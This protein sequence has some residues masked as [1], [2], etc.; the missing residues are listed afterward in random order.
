M[1]TYDPTS[2]GTDTRIRSNQSND[3]T[4]TDDL[5]NGGDHGYSANV[6]NDGDVDQDVS[7]N[8]D[9]SVDAI[10]QAGDGID[11]IND[12]INVG[13]DLTIDASSAASA[14]G[15]GVALAFDQGIAMGANIQSNEVTGSVTGGNSDIA[16]VGGDGAGL[17]SN[18][19]GSS[20]GLNDTDTLIRA[21]QSNTADD[22][23]TLVD[24]TVVNGYGNHLDQT[25]EV[26]GGDA[27]SGNGIISNNGQGAGAN[28]QVGDDESISGSTAAQA[29]ASGLARSFNQNLQTGSNQQGNNVD[30]AIT[31][32]DVDVASAG[33]SGA[34]TTPSATTSGNSDTNT[35]GRVNQSN[36]L[37]DGV[38]DDYN[39]SSNFDGAIVDPL[40]QNR[41]DVSQSI[42]AEGGEATTED[43]INIS[44]GF[45][46]SDAIVGGNSEISGSALASTSA[47][48][49]AVS[50]K[51][52]I[53]AGN[54]QQG[55]TAS[56]DIVGT[57]KG[58]TSS[59]EDDATTTTVNAGSNFRLESETDTGAR[60]RQSNNMEDQDAVHSAD[61][62]NLDEVH[63][64][65][66]VDGGTAEAGDGIVANS[67]VLGAHTV[68]DDSS[69][70]GSAAASS[71]VTGAALSFEQNINTGGNS[72]LNS[73]NLDVTGA[74]QNMAFAGEDNATSE[75]TSTARSGHETFTRTRSNQSNE[76]DDQD[77]V[78]N[79]TTINAGSVDQDIDLEA[80]DATSG[81]GIY[82]SG[83]A[84]AV[85]S[86]NSEIVGST[87]ASADAQ[88][89]AQAFNQQVTL[90]GNAQGNEAK[91]SVIGGELSAAS[92]GA[93]TAS[94]TGSFAASSTV[95]D[96]IALQN[97]SNRLSDSDNAEN[98]VVANE[99]GSELDQY[100]HAHGDD[101]TS[102]SGIVVDGGSLGAT[103]VGDDSS[104]SGSSSASANGVGVAKAFSQQVSTGENK[105]V[106][107][108]EVEV[109]GGNEV[110]A[111]AGESDA[112][113]SL[114]SG[115]GAT[116]DTSS[117]TG[118]L[119]ANQLGDGDRLGNADVTNKGTVNQEV[120]GYG[121]YAEAGDG[122]NTTGDSSA[123]VGGNESISGSTS[124]SADG[125]AVAQAF[126]QTLLSGGNVQA[127]SASVEVTG[128]DVNVA[129]SGE[130]AAS[131]TAAW[132]GLSDTD[133]GS[134]Q[135][136]F[137]TSQDGDRIW[138]ADVV[139]NGD[140]NQVVDAEGDEADAGNGI[141]ST[142]AGQ[143]GA[144]GAVG[145][146]GDSTITGSAAA[147][148]DATGAAS[149]FE[150]GIG[151]GGN[152]QGNSYSA[153]LTG[154][155]SGTAYA[156]EN[157]ASLA[158]L[159]Q[160]GPIGQS[161]TDS[162]AGVLQGND[163]SDSDR[164]SGPSVENNGE[165]YQTVDAEGGS[166]TAGAGIKVTARAGEV[167][168]NTVGDD[169]SITGSTSASADAV[170]SAS[171]MN[172]RIFTGGNT[173]N[174]SAD[175]KITGGS[176]NIASAGE[177]NNLTFAS[178]SQASVPGDGPGF[179]ST[180][181]ALG[182]LQVN[183]L[184]DND[185]VVSAEVRND[186]DDVG[187]TVTA[188]GG[189]ADAGANTAGIDASDLKGALNVGDNSSISGTASASADATAEASAFNQVIVSGGNTQVNQTEIDI[190]GDNRNVV[191]AGDDIEAAG[192]G[193]L[194]TGTLAGN[195]DSIALFAQS[196]DAGDNDQITDAL[197]ENYFGAAVNQEVT[198]TGGE[199]ATAGDGIADHPGSSFSAGGSI[200][201]D[202]TVTAQ[203]VAS[204]DATAKASAF[205]QTLMS[206]GNKQVNA[207]ELDITGQ[208]DTALF[209]GEDDH[210][211]GLQITPAGGADGPGGLDINGTDTIFGVEQ[212]NA[213]SD[214][215]VIS[216]AE[217]HNHGELTQTVSADGGEA[218][219]ADG[220]YDAESMYD[221]GTGDDYSVTA[222]TAATADALGVAN[223]FNQ[224]IVMGANVQA[225]AV[226]V[227]VVGGS[228]T[229]NVVGEDDLA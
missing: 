174:N 195:A 107:A 104:I 128:A 196:N 163:L 10:A 29:D 172:Q 200:G 158:Q 37:N 171:A 129:S 45:V 131:T 207:S 216:G 198:V 71:D 43:G 69:I 175:V 94:A 81:D 80:G 141:I 148:A 72:Q 59:A 180:D 189:D 70:S 8:A 17:N 188:I 36:D 101:A 15:Q 170:A 137:N 190:V 65:I 116:H 78:E 194:R 85:V 63:Q 77:W 115:S 160:N 143:I 226:D 76:M 228:S 142:G 49:V 4:D 112:T 21:R 19:T 123:S 127:N 138:S 204:A 201:D 41:H 1:S 125:Q 12:A 155:N 34:E 3:I 38:A 60:F 95:T 91:V 173:Q 229:V 149:A 16:S 114:A 166:A 2:Q 110:S 153:D 92:A 53:S 20:G 182:G 165:L 31:G 33:G 152:A 48:G 156:A 217:L 66:D 90:G 13:D 42:E 75:L 162:F 67:A 187:Q 82:T 134:L 83:G 192:N 11:D 100:I 121:Y 209:S 61:V 223:A 197:V 22:V 9:S 176:E 58:A 56:L 224:T 89:V 130:D 24:A 84:G 119:Q 169:S 97:Q 40:V 145:V 227:N 126:N 168:A 39:G 51:Q 47:S 151:S 124:A 102:G 32:S 183:S 222:S 161:D 178:G 109:T 106:N 210:M 108:S 96:T 154:A 225:N 28:G 221:F 35:R 73:S 122:I 46:G 93:D 150:Q 177:D 185:Q 212:A 117:F 103:D 27:E 208:N 159:A 211:P 205:N 14:S 23:D 191:S 88:G 181:S 218:Y 25:I 135:A 157:D 167:G 64:E 215:D 30:L 52:D 133:T 220:I 57:G 74:S 111:Y 50:F 99:S 193:Q 202:Y 139:N 186:S 164:V 5:I 55:N 219:A 54:N 184:T 6:L 199:E 203:S 120:E 98:P 18:Q 132:K 144:S 179:E 68:H 118:G 44:G 206:G 86:G 7:V 87:S 140:L 147:S 146:G 136:Q 213:L 79:P 26:Y 105:Q 62:S 113:S 214:Q